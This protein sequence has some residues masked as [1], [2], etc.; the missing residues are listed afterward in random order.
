[1]W[2][3]QAGTGV[4]IDRLCTYMPTLRSSPPAAPNPQPSICPSTPLPLPPHPLAGKSEYWFNT[5]TSESRWNTPPSCGWKRLE[6]AH[7]PYTYSN[8]ITGQTTHSVPNALSWKR[9]RLNDS[10]LWYNWKVRVAAGGC[11]C[12]GGDVLRWVPWCKQRI[13]SG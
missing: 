7:Q 9:V 13:C 11:V 8:V 2:G 1:M 3:A 4:P 6:V 12:G 5:K 10:L